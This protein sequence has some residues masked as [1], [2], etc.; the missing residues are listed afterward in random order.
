MRL[1]LLAISLLPLLSI[2]FVN[3]HA[4]TATSACYLNGNNGTPSCAT[5]TATNQASTANNIAASNP[6]NVLTGNKF[7]SVTD[8]QAIGGEYGLSFNR[9]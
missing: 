7:E 2:P 5:P 3:V 8:V 9:Y 4:K 6:I 1:N